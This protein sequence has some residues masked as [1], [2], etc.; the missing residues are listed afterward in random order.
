VDVLEEQSRSA[1][2]QVPQAAAWAAR[3]T[4]A[5]PASATSVKRFRQQAAPTIVRNAAQ[6]IAQARVAD[7]DGM[8]RDLLVEAIDACAEGIHR[9]SNGNTGLD[10]ARWAAACRRTGASPVVDKTMSDHPAQRR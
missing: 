1:L 7:P 6:G 2:A 5:A 9:G 3:F 8:L 4:R 10:M